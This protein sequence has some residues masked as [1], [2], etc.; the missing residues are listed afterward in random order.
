MRLTFCRRWVSVML[1]AILLC[2]G[3]FF[4]IFEQEGELC[5]QHG[6]DGKVERCGVRLVTLPQTDRARIR[7]GIFCA[8]ETEL[9]AELENF[10]S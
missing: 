2:G 4:R 6:S 1:L 7:R 10:I 9:A 5:V 8:D 3:S